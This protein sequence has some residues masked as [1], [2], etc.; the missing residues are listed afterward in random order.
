MIRKILFFSLCLLFTVGL[1]SQEKLDLLKDEVGQKIDDNAKMAQ[2]MVDKV[3]T[4][5][6]QGRPQK[7]SFTSLGGEVEVTLRENAL[8]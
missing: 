2:V 6:R 7:V 3:F 1:R 5:P 8:P 4:F